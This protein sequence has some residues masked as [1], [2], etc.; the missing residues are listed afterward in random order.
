M[1]RTVAQ[2]DGAMSFLSGFWPSYF[3]RFTLP[4]NSIQGRPVHGL[5]LRAGTATNRRGVLMVGGTHSR[6]LMNPD[7]LLE[8]A[9]DLMVS[10]INNSDITYGGFTMPA[11]TAKTILESM[12]LWFVPCINPD[13]RT[14]VLTT[15]DMWRKNRR[16][17]AG[18]TCD[19]VDLNRNSDFVFGV[20]Q[21]STSCSPCSDVYCGPG[22]FSEPETRNVRWLLDTRSIVTFVDVH[23]FSELVLWPWG[24]APSQTTD[25][26]KVF[27]TLP[28]GTCSASIPGTYAEYIAPRDRERFSTVGQRISDAI[29]QVRG[30]S[31]KSQASLDLYA[32]TGTLDDYAFSRHIANPALGKTYGFTFETG[33][34]VGDVRESFHPANPE[35][36]KQD[37]K[38]GLLTLM[39]QSICAI[40]FIGARSRTALTGVRVARELRDR[41]FTETEPGRAWIT[42]AEEL[43]PTFAA[44]AVRRPSLAKQGQGLLKRLG[45]L[46]DDPRST[47]SDQ[48]VAELTALFDG[49]G[50]DLGKDHSESINACRAVLQD[51]V[52]LSLDDAVTHLADRMPS[53]ER[54]TAEARQP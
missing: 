27:T 32:T 19:G 6:E 33:P 47:L 13:G 53:T 45:A 3:T 12:D 38:A 17:N 11:A 43:S 24:H 8:V 44:T 2:L 15:D 10:H 35:P 22:A 48:D 34:D 23:S 49:L 25:P 51:L 42:L 7:A 39:Q 52:G 21:G 16:D 50:R 5:R 9:I 20:A 14:Y 36:I 54:T 26:S 41:R 1:Y 40:D 46:A 18:T 29:K 30:R 4:E 37:A 28:T 31:Y